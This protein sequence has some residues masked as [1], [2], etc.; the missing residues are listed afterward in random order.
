MTNLRLSFQGSVSRVDDNLAPTGGTAGYR[1]DILGAAF[2]ANPTW[3]N[4]PDFDGGTLVNPTNLLAY[5]QGITNTNRY[6]ANLSLEYDLTSN[7][8]AKVTLG[9]DQVRFR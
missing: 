5:T 7:L 2:S 1:G 3:P 4:D 8:K 6:L 9:L